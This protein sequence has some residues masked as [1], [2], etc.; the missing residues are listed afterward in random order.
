MDIAISA[1]RKRHEL[2]STVQE[3]FE[4]EERYNLLFH[5]QHLYSIPLTKLLHS[6]DSTLQAWIYAFRTAISDRDE[7]FHISD[8]QQSAAL[9][10]FLQ[11]GTILRKR[12]AQDMDH[13]SPPQPTQKQPRK[14]WK[15]NR[16][17]RHLPLPFSQ[18]QTSQKRRKLTSIQ[19]YSTIPHTYIHAHISQLWSI[20]GTKEDLFKGSWQPP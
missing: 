4:S 10:A 16:Y 7:Q 17:R 3:L 2:Q 5:D 6:P 20:H 18:R 9:H 15:R 12:A 1:T 19:E 11:K 8:A 14:K 13:A